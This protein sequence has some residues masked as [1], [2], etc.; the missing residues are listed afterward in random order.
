MTYAIYS[1]R[2][3]LAKAPQVG[4]QVLDDFLRQYIRLRQV[5]GPIGFLPVSQNASTI[6]SSHA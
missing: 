4:L 3:N 5:S 6:I 2:Q 1:V